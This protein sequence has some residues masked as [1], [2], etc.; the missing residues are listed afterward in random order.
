MKKL[1]TEIPKQCV[2]LVSL[3]GNE[4]IAYKC[5]SE[6]DSHALLVKINIAVDPENRIYGYG[7]IPINSS[8]SN[9]RYKTSSWY[10]SIKIALA[11]GRTLYVFENE[12]DLA[13]A[14]LNNLF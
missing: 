1:I 8:N 4:I 6:L 14:I 11:G 12:K 2:D 13:K 3:Q 5:K 7:F 10:E 9:V